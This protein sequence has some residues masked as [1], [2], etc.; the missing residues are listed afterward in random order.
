MK[1]DKKARNYFS[2]NIKAFPDGSEALELLTICVRILKL[3]KNY[4]FKEKV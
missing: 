1:A 2:H 3:L 4:R